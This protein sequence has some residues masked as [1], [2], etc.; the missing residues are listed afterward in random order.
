MAES[1]HQTDVAIVGAGPVGLFAVFECGMLGLE[2]HLVDT[3]ETV[4]G[5][6][7]ALYPE[8]P[9]YDI[10]GIPK[11]MA[12]ELIAR[13]AEQAA[14]FEPA[15]HL[16]QQVIS[17]TPA[18]AGWRLETSAGTAIEARAVILAAGVGAF[19]PHR[20]PLAGIE[21]YEGRSVFYMVSR[22]ED[23]RDKRV[24]IAG[25]GDSALDWVLSLAEV[26]RKVYVVHRRPKFR[27]APETVARMQEL[28]EAGDVV[29]IV[30]PYVL[31]GLEGGQ[32]RLEAVV[33]ATLKGETRR[34]EADVLLPFFGLSMN[35]GPIADWGLG[36]D[37]YHIVVDPASCATNRAGVFAIGDVASYPGK[38][39]LILSGF[40]E[41]ALA[42]HAIYKLVHPDQELH[43]EYSTTK[44][45]PGG[46]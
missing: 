40:S 8:K 26:A 45:V 25:G 15:Y 31:H 16:G 29:E 46:G 20:P 36:L 10:P 9:I 39:K 4:G 30:V 2:C 22:R 41:A 21:D 5:Q 19:G 11:L 44:G 34:L 18:E 7:V 24:V 23:F 28:A 6:C 12:G 33:V 42:A 14:P 17:L 43:W 13:L 38:L 32:G 35:L 3:L 1:R 27:G 37:R